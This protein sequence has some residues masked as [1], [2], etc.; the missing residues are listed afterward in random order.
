MVNTFAVLHRQDPA[1]RAVMSNIALYEDYAEADEALI[2]EFTTTTAGILGVWAPTVEAKRRM[3]MANIL[4]NTIG[5]LLITGS[6]IETIPFDQVLVELKL[7]LVRYLEPELAPA[8]SN[9]GSKR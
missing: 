7:M 5:G 6:R 8:A 3:V 1:F 4:V 2:A 9:G